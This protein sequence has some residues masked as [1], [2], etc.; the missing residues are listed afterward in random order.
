MG[1]RPYPSHGQ[2]RG[3][4]P[5]EQVT[6]APCPHCGKPIKLALSQG[7][8]QPWDLERARR[9]TLPFGKFKGRS[10]AELAETSEG[11]D[12]LRWAAENMDGNAGIACRLVLEDVEG[13][14]L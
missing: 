4:R 2:T 5:N 9:F 10:L 11:M 1:E 7:F 6:S 13:G 14:D 8:G 3:Q 12:Y